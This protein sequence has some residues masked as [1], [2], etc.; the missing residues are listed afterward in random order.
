MR[1]PFEAA[2]PGGDAG[3]EEGEDSVDQLLTRAIDEF[4]PR[5][6]E[7]GDPAFA[8]PLGSAWGRCPPSESLIT[9]GSWTLT[10]QL[11]ARPSISA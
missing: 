5:L 10:P 8:I 11:I 4:E 1:T 6:R 9:Q 3:A 2:Y 7:P